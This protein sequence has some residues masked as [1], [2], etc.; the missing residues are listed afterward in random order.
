MAWM[1]TDSVDSYGNNIFRPEIDRPDAEGP[2]A[3]NFGYYVGDLRPQSVLHVEARSGWTVDPRS[4]MRLEAAY[5]FRTTDPAYGKAYTTHYF[6]VGLVC[7]FRE[8]HP[9]Q[10]RRYIIR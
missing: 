1:G 9:E 7:H 5:T 2:G 4:A 8:R 3:V 6:R 10:A